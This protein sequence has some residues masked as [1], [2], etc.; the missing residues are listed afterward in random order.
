MLNIALPKGR[1]GEAVY[2]MFAAA[3]YD[4]PAIRELLARGFCVTDSSANFVLA[5]TGCMDGK[6]L[7]EALKQRGILVRHF[8]D[9]HICHCVRITIGTRQQMDSLLHAIDQIMGGSI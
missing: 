6:A 5:S 3:G 2:E 1:L 7:Y 4:C 8:S 9:P